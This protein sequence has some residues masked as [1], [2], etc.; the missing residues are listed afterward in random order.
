MQSLRRKNE[1]TRLRFRQRL[2]ELGARLFRAELASLLGFFRIVS[3]NG[4]LELGSVGFD[5]L[6]PSF[7]GSIVAKLTFG[8]FL[9]DSCITTSCVQV[10]G[11]YVTISVS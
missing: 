3:S 7:H 2:L 8:L 6:T 1:A 10:V 11:N 4:V 5:A 9:R